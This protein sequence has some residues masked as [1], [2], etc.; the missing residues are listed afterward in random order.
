MAS[1]MMHL[2]YKLEFACPGTPCS[3]SP[4]STKPIEAW[5]KA[6]ADA[7]STAGGRG[8]DSRRA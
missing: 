6:I 3:V 4:R 1:A 7:P 5:M 8:D 2:Y